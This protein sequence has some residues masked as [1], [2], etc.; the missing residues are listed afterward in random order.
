MQSSR[1]KLFLL[2]GMALV[3]RAHFAFSKNPRITSYGLNTGAIFGFTNSLLDVIHN[4]KPTHIAVAID[5]PAP[6]FRHLEYKEYKAQRQE[7]P[8]DIISAIPFIHKITEAFNVTL[9]AI[10]GVEA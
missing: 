5:P 1:P 2:D 7:T 9:L 6:T 8:E 10:D 4:Q 3:Y